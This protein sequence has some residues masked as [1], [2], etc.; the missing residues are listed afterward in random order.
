MKFYPINISTY[1]ISIVAQG[2]VSGGAPTTT[3]PISQQAPAMMSVQVP[4]S[5]PNGIMMQ[6]IQ[7]PVQQQ[8][9]NQGIQ[10]K[11]LL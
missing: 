5:T 1:T 7:V 2:G 10:V 8:P 9:Q 4:V 11:Q 6:T 3:G